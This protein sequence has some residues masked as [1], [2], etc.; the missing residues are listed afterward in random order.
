MLDSKHIIH[1]SYETMSCFIHCKGYLVHAIIPYH[2]HATNRTI[3]N[4]TSEWD[5]FPNILIKHILDT[6]TQ[7]KWNPM[8]SGLLNFVN[9]KL[10]MVKSPAERA[11]PSA[12]RRHGARGCWEIVWKSL[13]LYNK[14]RVHEQG[15]QTI[16][17]LRTQTRF[18]TNHWKTLLRPRDR[19]SVELQVLWAPNQRHY[20]QGGHNFE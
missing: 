17:A 5:L 8:Q 13:L 4:A 9:N 19:I 12:E 16:R 7:Y 2:H 20:L 10:K 14:S 11:S 1:L 15:F 6:P 3:L 18:S